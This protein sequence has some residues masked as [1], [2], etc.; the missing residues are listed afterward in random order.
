MKTYFLSDLSKHFETCPACEYTQ[1][2]VANGFVPFFLK[3][4]PR[5]I[6]VKFYFIIFGNGII[7]IHCTKVHVLYFIFGW[8]YNFYF[9]KLFMTVFFILNCCILGL[10]GKTIVAYT[11]QFITVLCSFM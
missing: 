9:Y 11:F 3:I 5:N 6:T 7:C 10:P 4:I 1:A 2:S 8:V